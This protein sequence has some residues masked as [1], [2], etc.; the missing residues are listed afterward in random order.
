MSEVQYKELLYF[1]SEKWY[2]AIRICAI[3]ELQTGR[4]NVPEN[5]STSIMH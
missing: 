2:L 1:D 4:K 3:Y 5:K